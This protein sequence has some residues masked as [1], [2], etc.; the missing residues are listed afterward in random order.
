M[1]K[2]DS[3]QKNHHHQKILRCILLEILQWDFIQIFQQEEHKDKVKEILVIK[4]E[5]WQTTVVWVLPSPK[6]RTTSTLQQPQ[7]K[8]I[9]RPNI[10]DKP[11][12]TVNAL[13]Y[14]QK[15]TF[16]RQTESI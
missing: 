8:H 1:V 12:A 6:L 16:R 5:S 13:I 14:M 10:N 11:C 3:L 4:K 7:L 9:L 2:I 15:D